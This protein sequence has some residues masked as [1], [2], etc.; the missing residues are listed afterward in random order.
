MVNLQQIKAWYRLVD[1][2][3]IGIALAH[4]LVNDLGDPQNFIGQKS[5]IR[6]KINYLPP[7]IM[8]KM[9]QDTDPPMWNRIVSYIESTPDFIFITLLDPCYPPQLRE[10]FHAPLFLTANG[11]LSLL[12]VSDIVGIVGTR[13]PTQYGKY[14]TEKIVTSLVANSFIVC[15]GLALGIDSV[16]HKTTLELKGKTIAV[17]AG[18]LDFIYP[19]QNKDLADRIKQHGLVISESMP[20]IPFEKYHFP[21][22][23]RII[24]GLSRAVCI[25]EGK[26]QSGAMITGKYALEQNREVYALPGDITKPEAEGPNFL[27]S[28]GAKPICTPDE[29]TKDLCIEY[30]AKSKEPKLIL[31]PEEEK[32][33][34]L[35]KEKGSPTHIDEL[36]EK[37]GANMGEISS[38][39][40][41]LE[42]KNAVRT[43]ENGKYVA[44]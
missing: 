9:E 16:A 35:L 37:T 23:N 26:I 40:F 27:I 1:T 30:E 3:C 39:L 29:I 10:I 14:I 25:V 42:I 4:R 24:S 17:M 12:K 6:D 31:T 5:G 22:R 36:I 28:Q 33:I 18:G 7:D 34:I 19:Q 43:A 15:S 11:D 21:Q 38:L 8:I 44:Y 41:M 32:I 20:C 13:K 2:K